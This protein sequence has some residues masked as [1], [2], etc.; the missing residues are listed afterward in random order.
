MEVPLSVLFEDVSEVETSCEF[1]LPLELSVDIFEGLSCQVSEDVFRALVFLVVARKG[2]VGCE[3]DADLWFALQRK[4]YGLLF[5]FLKDSSTGRLFGE[6]SYGREHA[7]CRVDDES[8]R[9]P[10]DGGVTTDHEERIENVFLTD[11][12]CLRGEQSVT[13]VHE[14]ERSQGSVWVVSLADKG[15][16]FPEGRLKGDVVVLHRECDGLCHRSKHIGEVLELDDIEMCAMLGMSQNR[17]GLG[18]R[19]CEDG[20]ENGFLLGKAWK[21]HL[22]KDRYV[23]CQKRDGYSIFL[24]NASP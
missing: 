14:L 23:V 10:L 2:S 19:C 12:G 8:E 5:E 7:G 9:L 20:T 17:K 3:C 18:F 11:G 24:W 13:K 6:E 4:A 15:V 22:K 16:V 1:G 21:G